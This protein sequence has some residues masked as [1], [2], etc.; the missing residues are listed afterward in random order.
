MKEHIFGIPLD[1]HAQV[2]DQQ[3]EQL[4]SAP[5]NR[6]RDDEKPK[7]DIDSKKKCDKSSII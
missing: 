6:H 5:P 1:V 2:T 7:H 3:I 4:K